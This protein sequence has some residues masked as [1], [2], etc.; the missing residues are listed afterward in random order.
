MERA[1]TASHIG[2]TATLPPAADAADGIVERYWKLYAHP[3]GQ[4]P[5]PAFVY[6]SGPFREALAR[7]LYDVVEVGGG[8]SVVTG[9]PGTGVTTLLRSLASTLPAASFC[10]GQVIEPARPVAGLI[11]VILEELGARKLPRSR[12]GLFDA[13]TAF[14]GEEAL[15]G[16]EAVV[17]IDEAHT[18]GAPQLEAIRRLTNIETNERKL[19][20]VVLAGQP[21]LNAALRRNASLADRVTMRATLEPLTTT[22]ADRY[23]A[24]RLRI[25]GAERDPFSLRAASRVV[26]SSKGNPRRINVI[27]TAALLAG[28]MSRATTITP[29]MVNAVARDAAED[30]K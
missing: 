4:S 16:R 28:A 3:F 19:L 21:K 6:E 29:A 17:L 7:V 27:A 25:A 9:A 10:V 2:T 30:S 11:R 13:A 8:L 20:H 22:D 18:M 23:I 12:S 24:H 5:N 15:Q 26:S 14:L 1:M